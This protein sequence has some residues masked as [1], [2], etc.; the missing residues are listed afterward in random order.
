MTLSNLVGSGLLNYHPFLFL[1]DIL[2]LW[3]IISCS[4]IL[5]KD[6]LQHYWYMQ[7]I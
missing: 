3:M 6:L 7:M 1:R 4:L 2:N 5:L